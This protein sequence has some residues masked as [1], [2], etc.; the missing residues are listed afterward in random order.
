MR[1]K[2]LAHVNF[3]AMSFDSGEQARVF[4]VA[5]HN[6]RPPLWPTHEAAAALWP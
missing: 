2:T 5:Y 1:R 3:S 4:S 6:R